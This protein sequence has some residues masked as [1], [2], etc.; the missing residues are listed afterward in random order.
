MAAQP[1][2]ALHDEDVPA[3]G[4]VR[5][6]P[7]PRGPDPRDEHLTLAAAVPVDGDPLAA[8]LEGEAIRAL[9]VLDRRVA[10]EVD[11]LRDAV[12]DVALEGVLHGE[13]LIDAELGRRDEEAPKIPSI[14]WRW[15]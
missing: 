13:V 6:R 12:V 14:A 15:A 5:G 9:H 10:R 2:R 1:A 4:A 3:L 8:E 7:D 11:G